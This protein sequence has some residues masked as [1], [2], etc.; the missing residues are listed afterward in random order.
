MQQHLGIALGSEPVTLLEQ[1]RSELKIVKDLSIED[2]THRAIFIEHR[3]IATRDIN[4]R[5]TPHT[6]CDGSLHVKSTRVGSPMALDI[7]H[8]LDLMDCR[9][10]AY[11]KDSGYAT[12]ERLRTLL[13]CV[14]DQIPSET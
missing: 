9:P 13:R 4:D 14:D 7:D 1:G 11:V 3:L 10:T 5:E 12:H 8:P 6:Q 2:D